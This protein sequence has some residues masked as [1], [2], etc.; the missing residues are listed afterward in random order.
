MLDVDRADSASVH[1]VG[2]GGC[3]DDNSCSLV[4]DS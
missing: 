3:R 1:N 2:D 4:L